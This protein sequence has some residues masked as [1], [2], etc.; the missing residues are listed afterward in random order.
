M[1][2]FIPV[3][4]L[5]LCFWILL[6]IRITRPKF[7]YHWLVAAIFAMIAW[8]GSLLTYNLPSSI[9][10]MTFMGVT[11]PTSSNGYIF[12]FD[13]TVWIYSTALTTLL[14]CT[15]LTCTTRNGNSEQ[16]RP[17]W[18]MLAGSILLTGFLSL[19]LSAGNLYT[20]LITWALA[21]LCELLI[22]IFIAS[23]EKTSKVMI[24]F[25]VQ[26]ASF[27]L[28]LYASTQAISIEGGVQM[29]N[30]PK[31][32]L[33]Y[34]LVASAL[35]LYIIPPFRP[36]TAEIA[37]NSSQEPILRFS[38]GAPALLLLTRVAN[39][40]DA[41]PI[42]IVLFIPAI[43]ASIAAGL[44]LWIASD[45]ILFFRRYW[46]VGTGSLAIGAALSAEPAA[47]VSFGLVFILAGGLLIQYTVHSRWLR[48]ILI[49]ASIGLFGLPLV[50]GWSRSVFF[51]I[52]PLITF[53]FLIAQSLMFSGYFLNTLNNPQWKYRA[54]TLDL[55][56]VWTWFANPMYLALLTSLD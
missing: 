20:L 25:F 38:T 48:P 32:I 19:V 2:A 18:D 51:L 39:A 22:W 46:T 10:H 7:A 13:R 30:L 47:S 53:V 17:T 31:S 11:G 9:F 34:L 24:H 29:I 14:F 12:F 50:L 5:F 16:L 4:V 35:R 55:V 52:P 36:L 8:I 21:D 3:V 6:G 44:A 1:A 56:I 28:L 26:V 49:L 40:S 27:S 41:L 43:I 37:S 23:P 33:P 15:F 54:R 42:V 45:N